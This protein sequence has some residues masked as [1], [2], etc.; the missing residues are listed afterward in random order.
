[1][2]KERVCVIFVILVSIAWFVQ[3]VLVKAQSNKEYCYGKTEVD[4]KE[5]L[6]CEENHFKDKRVSEAGCC[7]KCVQKLGKA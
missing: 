2:N 3:K 7:Q 6:E 4:C 1:M 5:V